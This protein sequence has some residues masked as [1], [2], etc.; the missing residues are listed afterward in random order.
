VLKKD[1]QHTTSA[2]AIASWV[3]ERV[4]KH[5]RLEGGVFFTQQ[6]PKNPTGKIQ[7]NVIKGWG[8]MAGGALKSRL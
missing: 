4:A 2:N 7:R 3:A 5:K 6:I 8:S 1:T